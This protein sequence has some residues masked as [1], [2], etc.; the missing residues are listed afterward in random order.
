[1]IAIKKVL[2][3]LDFPKCKVFSFN[4][5]CSNFFQKKKRNLL[6]TLLHIKAQRGHGNT[7]KSIN[8]EILKKAITRDNRFLKFGILRRNPDKIYKNIK[9]QSLELD[10]I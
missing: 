10:C 2:T 9:R 1:M 7:K 8:G 5:A 6:T 3:D 4:R